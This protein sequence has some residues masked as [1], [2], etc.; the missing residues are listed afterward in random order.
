[1]SAPTAVEI[2]RTLWQTDNTSDDTHRVAMETPVALVFNGISHVVMMSTPADL[3]E[4]ALGFSLSEGILE[5]PEQLLDCHI[6]HTDIL[7]IDG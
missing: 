2:T 4:F 5:T 1:M 3:E 6:E 7:T